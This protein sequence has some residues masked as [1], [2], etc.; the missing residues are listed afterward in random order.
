VAAESRSPLLIVPPIEEV[1]TS[2]VRVQ[3]EDFN[4]YIL[5]CQH[6]LDGCSSNEKVYQHSQDLGKATGP[7]DSGLDYAAI[8]RTN[9]DISLSGSIEYDG[10]NY[11]VHGHTTNYEVLAEE[12]DTVYK[13][14]ITT[15]YTKG[16]VKE[17]NASHSEGCTNL[18]NSDTVTYSNNQAQGDSG[19]APF[20]LEGYGEPEAYV[21]GLATLAGGNEVG[22]ANCGGSSLPI[23]ELAA[24]PS[25]E[26]I[27]EEEDGDLYFG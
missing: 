6:F 3:D 4:F 27:R 13:T 7:S 18:S 25:A 15:G 20:I 16:Q 2:G 19:S 22:E 10:T 11:Q 5:T 12:G 21:T 1:C 9:D 24:G 8:E 23:R 26:A 14:G 17:L